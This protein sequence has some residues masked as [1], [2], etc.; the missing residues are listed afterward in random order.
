MDSGVKV[1]SGEAVFIAVVNGDVGLA[2]T[3][4]EIISWISAEAAKVFKA[5]DSL[6]R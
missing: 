3:G 5:S 2:I 1:G 6:S 4:G